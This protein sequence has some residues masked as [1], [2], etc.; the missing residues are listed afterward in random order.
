MRICHIYMSVG[1]STQTY[2][3]R[4]GYFYSSGVQSFEGARLSGRTACAVWHVAGASAIALILPS[5]ARHGRVEHLGWRFSWYVYG[6]RERKHPRFAAY[7]WPAV[8]TRPLRIQ[9]RAFQLGHRG[10]ALTARESG[11]ELACVLY[12]MH[13]STSRVMRH[14]AANY[15]VI[16][17]GLAGF[18][19]LRRGRGPLPTSTTRSRM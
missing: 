8:E 18:V 10:V 14:Y 12:A 19:P 17:R 15:G 1:G 6:E 3:R 16:T 7:D 4:S 9:A 2:K 11:D 13:R 5:R